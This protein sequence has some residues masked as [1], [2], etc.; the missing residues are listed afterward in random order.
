VTKASA[1]QPIEEQGRARATDQE[2]AARRRALLAVFST[3]PIAVAA[4]W[5]FRMEGWVAD[6]PYWILVTLLV[7]TGIA[8][9]I[10]IVWLRGQ[11][12]DPVRIQ[13]RLCVSTLATTSVIYAV[14]WGPM[15]V[16]AYGV[17]FAT[18]LQEAGSASWRSGFAW[19]VIGVGL[20]QAAIELGIAPTLIDLGLANALALGGLVCFGVVAR[21]LG[22]KAAAAEEAEHALRARGEQFRALLQHAVD[23]IAVVDRDGTLLFASPAVESMLGY[24][25]DDLQGASIAVLVPEFELDR[26]LCRIETMADEPGSS[27][28]LCS[29]QLRHRDG[30]V[31]WSDTTLTNPA[32]EWINSLVLNVHDITKQR[33]LEEQLRHDALHDPLTGLWNRPAFSQYA[34]KACLRAGRE[35]FT[36]ALLF[37]DLDGFKQ[38]NDTLGHGLGDEVLIQVGRRLRSCLRGTEVLA[39]LGGDEFTVLIERIGSAG[40]AIDIADR[41][42][43]TLT[44]PFEGP[45]G[46]LY[47]GASV[48]IALSENGRLSAAELLRDADHA[49]Y[50]AKRSG[51]SGWRLA[52]PGGT[53][54]AVAAR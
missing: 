8:N 6:T 3:V 47:L 30:T 27:H 40:D 33:E 1:E 20:G 31:R 22:V 16:I 28:T 46:P 48:G 49:M 14:G 50:S 2:R 51:R 4:F 5:W 39:R 23:V 15:L 41:I 26:V 18:V 12:E 36:L 42:H 52:E 32:G 44:R 43:A 21:V 24:A 19:S 9:A 35:G 10:S 7:G 38:V 53:A 45:E 37:V 17:G 29:L 11:P 25:P 54:S 34:E 13:V